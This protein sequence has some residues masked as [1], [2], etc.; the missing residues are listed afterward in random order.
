MLSLFRAQHFQRGMTKD[1]TDPQ[2]AGNC[3]RWILFKVTVLRSAVLVYVTDVPTD[4]SNCTEKEG[5]NKFIFLCL[6]VLKGLHGVLNKTENGKVVTEVTQTKQKSAFSQ[7][8]VL[9]L[10]EMTDGTKPGRAGELCP[11]NHYSPHCCFLVCLWVG[12]A[13][14]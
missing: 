5:E 13:V 8:P 9:A 1:A 6:S 11:E 7:V 2:R 14:N 3:Q 10:C 4:L 12:A